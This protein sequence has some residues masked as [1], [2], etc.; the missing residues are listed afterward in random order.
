MPGQLKFNSGILPWYQRRAAELRKKG[1]IVVFTSQA[2][3]NM[4]AFHPIFNTIIMKRIHLLM[5][6]LIIF[7]LSSCSVIEGIFKAGAVVGVIAVIVVI[8][9]IVWLISLFRK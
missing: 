6:G 7:T 9:I 5:I 4:L 2:G 1:V 3:C 8:L